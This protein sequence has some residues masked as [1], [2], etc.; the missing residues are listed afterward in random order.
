VQEAN[1]I[2]GLVLADASLYWEGGSDGCFARA[3][4]VVER[5]EREGIPAG[6]IGKLLVIHKEAP[7][8]GWDVLTL[9]AGTQR[10]AQHVVPTVETSAGPYVIDPT[11]CDKAEAERQ[12]LERFPLQGLNPVA[13]PTP[14]FLRSLLGASDVA[15][16]QLLALAGNRPEF[17]KH[18]L[19]NP[20]VAARLEQL[21]SPVRCW[22]EQ[23]GPVAEKFDDHL[24]RLTA[25]ANQAGPV[26]RGEIIRVAHGMDFLTDVFW[27]LADPDGGRG[28]S[29]ARDYTAD[30]RVFPQNRGCAARDQAP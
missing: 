1:A 24:V 10:W 30:P 5:M 23:R 11:L 28:M 21:G 6:A 15:F 22:L 7:K 12:W 3:V 25:A 16:Q 9:L 29:D 18:L 19:V 4:L 2:H 8:R 26:V 17:F 27:D 13:A 20:A 14:G